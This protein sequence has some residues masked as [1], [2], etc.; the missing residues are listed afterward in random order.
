MLREISREVDYVMESVSLLQHLSAGTKYRDLRESL[1]KKYENTLRE[2]LRKFELLERIE[3]A[4]ER[5]FAGDM[6][7]LQYYFPA[8]DDAAM[9]CVGNLLLLWENYKNCGYRDVA[10]YGKYLR[11]LSEQEYC[12]RFGVCLQGYTEAIVRDTSGILKM[13]DPYAVIS[14]LMKM[15]IKDEEKWKIQK[16]FFD[17]TEHMEKVLGF[18]EKAEDLL[19]GFQ[20][21]LNEMADAFC[22]YWT[23]LLEGREMASYV[24]ETTNIKIEGSPLGFRIQVSIICNNI[25]MMHNDMGDDG[26]TYEE[27]DYYTIGVL[28]GEDFPLSTSPKKQREGIESDA[29]QVLKLLADKSKFQILS[30]IHDKAAYGSELA[31]HLNL[32]TATVSHHMNVLLVAGLVEVN[33]IENR[34]YYTANKEA[35]GEVLDYCK[36]ILA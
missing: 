22:K 8:R 17:R 4:A 10:A 16:I 36:E 19:R 6:E 35:I 5:V 34:V 24:M 30:Y 25:I 14:Y 26:K 33:H 15:E 2:G 11:E 3:Q 28:F 9:G 27:P 32:T 23:K 1:N 7:Q 20:N 29:L 13:R 12:E 21:E 31:K 18:M